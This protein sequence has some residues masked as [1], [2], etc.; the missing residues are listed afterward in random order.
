[1]VIKILLTRK[2]IP[3]FLRKQSLPEETS[4]FLK[5]K[6]KKKKNLKCQLIVESLIKIFRH[7]GRK[8]Q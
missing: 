3:L 4:S 8:I 5:K 7:T 2:V 6:K 1:M